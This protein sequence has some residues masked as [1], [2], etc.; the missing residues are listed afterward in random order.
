MTAAF[1]VLLYHSEQSAKLTEATSEHRVTVPHRIPDG[2]LPE[3]STHRIGLGPL[4]KP[5]LLVLEVSS[6]AATGVQGTSLESA[7][8]DG[9][10]RPSLRTIVILV[11]T[12]TNHWRLGN[13]EPS[14][15]SDLTSYCVLP[16]A[17]SG[18]PI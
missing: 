18:P 9:S 14:F 10:S 17:P 4:T 3:N 11:H 5:S 1:R 12:F 15:F 13:A 7:A 2:W 8:Q 16:P 6:L